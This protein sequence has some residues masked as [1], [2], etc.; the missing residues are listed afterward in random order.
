M[1]AGIPGKR[2]AAHGEIRSAGLTA[3]ILDLS[4]RQSSVLLKICDQELLAS[5]RQQRHGDAH[6]RQVWSTLMLHSLHHIRPVR[7][8]DRSA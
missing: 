1:A 2:V 6:C 4:D 5:H 3:Q 7:R 8:L